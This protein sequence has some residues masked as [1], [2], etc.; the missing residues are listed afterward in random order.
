MKIGIPQG[1]YFYEYG[2]L[3]KCFLE[4]LGEDVVISSDTS[5]KT[6]KTGTEICTG[7][8]CL[9]IKVYHGHIIDLLEKNPDALFLPR[10]TKPYK[11]TFTCPKVMG[12]NDMIRSA[13]GNDIRIIEPTLSGNLQRFCFSTGQMLGYFPYDIIKAYKNLL[14]YQNQKEFGEAERLNEDG[15]N[16]AII[17]HP[18][19]VY[20]NCVN[21]NIEKMLKEQGCNVLTPR[22]FESEKVFHN[23]DIIKKDFFW[24]TGD[25]SMNF[26]NSVSEKSEVDGIIYLSSFGCGPDAFVLPFLRKCA[27]NNETLFIDLSFDEHTGEEGVK[28]RVEAFVEMI[29]RKKEVAV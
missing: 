16:I 21:M 22:N 1:L 20:E 18:Y 2:D 17:G 26:I 11:D 14:K 4:S 3:W 29:R 7:G 27:E 24:S 13:V 5:E 8:A 6:I 25:K 23:P 10:I 12:V 9:P 19:L 15:I 28:T